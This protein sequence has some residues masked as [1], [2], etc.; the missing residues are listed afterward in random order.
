MKEIKKIRSELAK[1]GDAVFALPSL[2]FSLVRHGMLPFFP[3]LFESFQNESLR[4]IPQKEL[5]KF[6]ARFLSHSGPVLIKFG[7]ILATRTD[8]LPELICQELETLYDGQ[9]PMPKSVRDGLL[10]RRYGEKIPFKFL[11]RKPIGVG[12]IGEVYRAKLNDGSPIVV[13]II[14]PGILRRIRRDIHFL[15]TAMN[16]VNMQLHIWDKN[17]EHGM[18]RALMELAK[19]L[20]EEAD[21]RIEAAALKDFRKRFR[22]NGNVYVPYCY[23]RFCDKNILVME[24]IKGIPLSKA[25]LKAKKN[26]KLAKQIANLALTEILRQ[27]FEEGRFHADPHGGN[28]ILMPDGR[29]GIIDLG[30]TGE[31]GDQERKRIVRALRAFIAKDAESLISSLLEF[32]EVP[33]NFNQKE[34]RKDVESIVHKHKEGLSS[35]LRGKSSKDRKLPGGSRSQTKQKPPK[36]NAENLERFVTDLFQVAYKHGIYVPHNSVLLIKTLVTIEGLARSIDPDLNLV[37]QA[38]PIVLRAMLPKWLRWPTHYAWH[39]AKMGD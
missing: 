22:R 35:Q 3:S 10:R 36:P 29:L 26:K 19:G 21:L 37:D 24:E 38:L 30:L 33:D 28:L 11:D 13:K 7:Q 18:R 25:R 15:E 39:R 17:F 20:E 23:T 16:I 31:F 12:S 32:G 6:L 14:R 5:G 4:D 34:F 27:I 8:I 9:E 2:S 1:V